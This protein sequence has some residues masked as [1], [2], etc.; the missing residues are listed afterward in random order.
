MTCVRMIEMFSNDYHEVMMNGA[1]G[2]ILNERRGAAVQTDC[3]FTGR[4]HGDDASIVSLSTCTDGMTDDSAGYH[5]LNSL[6]SNGD[7]SAAGVPLSL[8]ASIKAFGE[9]VRYIHQYHPH[10]H[11]SIIPFV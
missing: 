3:W 10:L 6:Q 4:V 5:Q 7:G 9:Q 2:E 8:H 11:H 1:T